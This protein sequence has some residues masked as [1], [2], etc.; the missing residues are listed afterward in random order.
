MT[1]EQQKEQFSIAYVRAVAAAARVNIYK[2]E[3]DDDS[4][5]IGFATRITS[6]RPSRP[7]IEAQLKCSAGIPEKNGGF[8]YPLLLKNYND[9]SGDDLIPRIL[10]VLMVPPKTDN[11][12]TQDGDRMIVRKAA[13]WLSLAGYPVTKNK[14]SVTVEVPKANLFDPKALLKLL[15]AG[16]PS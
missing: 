1:L 6:G 8:R 4:I 12:L 7:R 14:T 3:V 2:L 13:F 5:D 10:I 16:T 9:L 11:W 15:K